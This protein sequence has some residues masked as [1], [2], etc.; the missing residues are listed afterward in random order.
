MK[1]MTAIKK[2]RLATLAP[3]RLNTHTAYSAWINHMDHHAIRQVPGH[4]NVYSHLY[5]SLC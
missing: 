4:A 1:T 2:A 3:E 5:I